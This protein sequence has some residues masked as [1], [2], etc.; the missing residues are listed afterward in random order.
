MKKLYKFF[1]LLFLLF[2]GVSF[3][4]GT[5][6]SW[7][8]FKVIDAKAGQGASIGPVPFGALLK[9]GL[10]QALVY[11]LALLLMT[12]FL[13]NR[14]MNNG[15]RFTGKH[16]IAVSGWFFLVTTVV[17]IIHY[18]SF[19]DGWLVNAI[20]SLTKQ[21]GPELVLPSILWCPFPLAWLSLFIILMAR[22]KKTE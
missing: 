18:I 2:L 14:S 16:I 10:L 13:L 6:M 11:S 15:Q 20:V 4:Y 5:L 19:P 17:Y 3:V 8:T 12:I 9:A 7:A 1:F 21:L 22:I